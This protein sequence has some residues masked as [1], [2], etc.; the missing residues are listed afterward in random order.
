MPVPSI[1]HVSLGLRKLAALLALVFVTSSAL[2]KGPDPAARILLEPLGF[3]TLQT[4]FLLAGSSMLTVDF[5][6][7]KHLLV[8]YSTK[9][10]LKRLSECPPSDQDRTIDAVLLELPG[11]KV[12]ARTAWRLHDRG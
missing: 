4:Q 1:I 7:E 3:Q 8:T 2:A 11:G 6:D 10:L 12:L 5:V 9:R